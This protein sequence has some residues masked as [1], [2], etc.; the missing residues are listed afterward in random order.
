[1]KFSIVTPS[2][3]QLDWLRLCV[4]SVRDQVL[5]EA[6]RAGLED[7]RQKIE[8]DKSEILPPISH[9]P[10]PVSSTLCVEHIIQ[11]AGTPGIEE[12][13]REVG[14]DF[15]RDGVLVF[16]S[17]EDGRW[18][19]GDEPST[20]R[21]RITVYSE[22]DAGM[23]DAVNKGFRRAEGDIYAYLN[24]DEQYLPDTLAE[25]DSQFSAS[26]QTEVF[27]CDAIVVDA[28]GGYLC[29]RRV[30]VPTRLHTLVSGNLSI[31]TSST[32][33]RAGVFTE[34]GIYFNGSFRNSGDAEWALRL[35]A[36]R[37]S[38]QAIRLRAAAFT[39]TGDNLNMQPSG[40]LE[41]AQLR[42]TAPVWAKVCKP[43]IVA[44]YR[45]RRFL[46]GIYNLTSHSY[47]IHTLE[48]PRACVRFDVP[49]PSFIWPG[50]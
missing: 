46:A 38:M 8:D 2:F 39:D 20:R 25:I 4:A 15:Y 16:G 3:N 11:D 19:M 23:Y 45:L 44:F 6:G 41:K 35:V 31:F 10:S 5:P 37:V 32:F 9:L 33:S 47:E 49:K 12:F 13:T 29:D 30:M 21:Y 7:G 22:S 28:Q 36:A 18:Q 43:L 14:A 26:H 48:S 27:F 40:L 42:A 50:R 17:T 24:C 34:R 1:M